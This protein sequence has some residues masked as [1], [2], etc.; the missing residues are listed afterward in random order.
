MKASVGRSLVWVV[1]VPHND[2]SPP[3]WPNVTQRLMSNTFRWLFRQ[4]NRT[5][6]STPSDH[7]WWTLCPLCYLRWSRW[8]L[9][10]GYERP[11]TPSPFLATHGTRNM[12]ISLVSVPMCQICFSVCRTWGVLC[13]SVLSVSVPSVPSHF[14][15]ILFFLS[16]VEQSIRKISEESLNSQLAIAL[17]IYKLFKIC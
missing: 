1:K 16:T 2:R 10:C 15:F 14:S 12:T 8:P 6:F 5:A 9:F 17:R 11:T 7:Q 13:A 3:Q 4:S